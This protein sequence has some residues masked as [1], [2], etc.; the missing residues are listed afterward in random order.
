MHSPTHQCNTPVH[1]PE[2]CIVVID[3]YLTLSLLFFSSAA[4]DRSIDYNRTL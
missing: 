1:E 4:I 3:S 2:A